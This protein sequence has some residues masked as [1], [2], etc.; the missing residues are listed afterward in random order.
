MTIAQAYNTYPLNTKKVR[1]TTFTGSS[2]LQGTKGEPYKIEK[3]ALHK[4]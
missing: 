3:L 2:I 1:G 4:G